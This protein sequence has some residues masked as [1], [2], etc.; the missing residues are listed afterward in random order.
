VT[1][2]IPKMK[3]LERV[4]ALTLMLWDE[5]IANT[6]YR[7]TKGYFYQILRHKALW[8]NENITPKWCNEANYKVLTTIFL[9]SE[10]DEEKVLGFKSQECPDKEL[11]KILYEWDYHTFESEL[12][13]LC[14]VEDSPIR[15]IDSTWQIISKNDLW[16]FVKDLINIQTVKKFYT[17]CKLALSDYNS[18]YELSIDDR[19][20]SSLY[21]KWTH[22]SER[23][24]NWI[25]HSLLMLSTFWDDTIKQGLWDVVKNIFNQLTPSEIIYSLWNN[26]E[27]LAEAYPELFLDF[28]EKNIKSLDSVFESSSNYFWAYTHVLWSLEI[29]STNHDLAP[30]VIKLLFWLVELYEGKIFLN[31]SN[32]PLWSL[33]EI[34]LPWLNHS[35]L[36]IKERLKLLE[37]QSKKYPDSVFQFINKLIVT[38]TSWN[39]AFPKVQSWNW[40]YNEEILRNDYNDYMKGLIDLFII[41]FKSNVQKYVLQTISHIHDFN[42]S[43]SLEVIKVIKENRWSRDDY[44]HLIPHILWE[45]E[46]D[47]YHYKVYWHNPLLLESNLY[48]AYN[49]LYR[50]LQSTDTVLKNIH[51]FENFKN[52]VLSRID[53]YKKWGSNWEN[54]KK[55]ADEERNK[56]LTHIFNERWF[57]WIY[58]LDS[59]LNEKRP[60]A[61]AIVQSWIYLK[62]EKEIQDLLHSTTWKYLWQGIVFEINLINPEWI[63]NIFIDLHIKDSD[64]IVNFLIW[65][66]LDKTILVKVKELDDKLRSIYWIELSK[67]R[68]FRLYDNDNEDGI[69]YVLNELNKNNLFRVSFE[70]IEIYIQNVH[71]TPMILIDTLQWLISYLNEGGFISWLQYY[72]NMVMNHLYKSYDEWQIEKKYLFLVEVNYIDAIDNPRFINDTLKESPDVFVELINNIYKSHSEKKDWQLSEKVKIKARNSSLILGKFK[73]VPWCENWVINEDIL[74]SWILQALKWLN[75]SDRLSIWSQRIWEL[76]VN[77]PVWND[78]IHPC[79]EIR[80]IFEDLENDD[81]EVWY[82]IAKENSR[83]VTSRWL[84]D[85]WEQERKLAKDYSTQSK[86]VRNNWWFRT[87]EILKKLSL[88]YLSEAKWHDNRQELEHF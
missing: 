66:P 16:V 4:Q 27:N 6:V 2:D 86:L 15:K 8:F 55:I 71:I 43:H 22:Y 84:Y 26:L 21:W 37:G 57:Q 79:E 36:S 77:A 45:I 24:R 44:I 10:W 42:I 65:L 20:C 50:S 78:E 64:F 82:I 69:N 58:E 85:G 68:R 33:C 61:H 76:L 60:L 12:Y 46:Q 74:K 83:G 25:S 40:E 62:V 41:I 31:T 38:Q 53:E 19:W 1:I 81:I 29:I 39:I 11:V 49:D 63:N 80:N 54:E 59:F 35:P 9:L 87:A 75:E 5:N 13:N 47:F 52:M 48:D 28:L 23:I 51:L 88:S 73:Q 32:R 3:R 34:L 18:S 56:E 7:D 72:L 17:V 14:R 30:K 67:T 70:Q